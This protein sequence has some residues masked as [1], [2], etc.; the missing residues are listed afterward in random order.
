MKQHVVLKCSNVWKNVV[1]ILIAA[2]LVIE[3]VLFVM[4]HVLVT[5]VFHSFKLNLFDWK[6]SDC[7]FRLSV[8]LQT[9]PESN[10]QIPIG[11]DPIQLSRSRQHSIQANALWLPRLIRSSGFFHKYKS[12]K[13]KRLISISMSTKMLWS[14]MI[15]AELGW[16]ES[17]IQWVHK[18]IPKMG[19]L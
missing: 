2:V 1:Q 9:M 12:F 13:V 14:S 15:H 16:M 10:L 17:I 8:W 19:Q 4:M 18:I 7:P 11:F 5:L 3:Q 6:N